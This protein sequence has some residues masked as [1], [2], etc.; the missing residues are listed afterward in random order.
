MEKCAMLVYTHS[1]YEDV[2]EIT[3]KRF[4]KYARD[5]PLYI[6]TD[7]E[8]LIREKYAAKYNIGGIYKYEDALNYQLK[9]ASVLER[10]DTKY[11]CLH[12]DNHCL[13]DVLDLGR[14]NA[15]IRRMDTSEI[16]SI[17]LS[18]VGVVEPK[19]GDSDEIA[20]NS[21][22][23][24][25]SVWPTIWNREAL[26]NICLTCRRAYVDSETP[27][28][29]SFVKQYNLYYMCASMKDDYSSLYQAVSDVY[30]SIHFI[31]SKKWYYGESYPQCSAMMNQRVID[32][33]T[34]YGIDGTIRGN[35]R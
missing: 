26:L 6:C 27:E 1:E 34:E 35:K 20:E 5:L 12:H 13:F 22:P 15:L 7:N 29:Q 25:Y 4:K 16:D 11:V 28:C 17:R 14:M 30:P 24:W 2:M 9:L 18:H 8:E 19:R 31:S 3:L 33:L 23:Y 10:I 32:I 21:G